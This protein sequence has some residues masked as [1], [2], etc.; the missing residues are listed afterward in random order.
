MKA[1]LLT[2]FVFISCYC[3]AQ[4]NDFFLLK[5]RSGATE[6]SFYRGTYISFITAGNESYSG[7]IKKV[8]KDSVWVEYREV[9]N[10]M[11]SIGGFISDTI[12]YEA[13]RFAVKDIR[14]I[15]KDEKGFEQ[16]APGGL[17][18][19]GGAGYILLHTIN[20]LIQNDKVSVKNISIAAGF[21]LVGVLLNKIRK[22]Y[23]YVG[24]RFQLQY[25]SLAAKPAA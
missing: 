4:D 18:K 1:L 7:F 5:K 24:K 15:Q 19:L 10:A 9:V 21:Y 6:K 13:R 25:I 23:Y 20:G 11:T 12:T 22:D 16:V 14:Y 2:T 17:L 3:F 8:A